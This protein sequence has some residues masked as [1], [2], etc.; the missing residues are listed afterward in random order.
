VCGRI[1]NID[2][3][4][5]ARTGIEETKKLH[6]QQWRK[7]SPEKKTSSEPR[8]QTL[9]GDETSVESMNRKHQDEPLCETNTTVHSDSTDDA[10][11]E[12]NC[13]PE[14]VIGVGTVPNFGEQIQ[15]FR[16]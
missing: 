10:R 7:G 16:I 12:I 13:S 8:R 11:I 14:F 3:G 1:L 2:R 5:D 15:E 9:I 6:G 4:G